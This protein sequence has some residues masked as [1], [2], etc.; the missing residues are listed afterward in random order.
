MDKDD[1]A[2][3]KDSFVTQWV[4]DRLETIADDVEFAVKRALFQGLTLPA[5]E[6]EALRVKLADDRGYVRALRQIV[7]LELEEIAEP[8]RDQS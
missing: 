8:E 1:F 7:E 4:F 5:A 6:F 2:Q 3:W